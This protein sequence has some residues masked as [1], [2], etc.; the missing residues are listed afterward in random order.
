MNASPSVTIM[1][2]IFQFFPQRSGRMTARSRSTPIRNSTGIRTARVSRVVE[3]EVAVGQDPRD[4]GTD[5]EEGS[6]GEV[7][8]SGRAVDEGKAH[9]EHAVDGA[10][11][12]AADQ[13]FDILHAVYACD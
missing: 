1:V 5:H 8:H 9:G 6:M 3:P 13:H 11:S 2:V 4:V 12:H 10:L 7:E